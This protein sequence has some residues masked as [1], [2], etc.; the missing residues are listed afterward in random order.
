[1][2]E[3]CTRPSWCT[4][5]STKAPNAATFV[6]TPSSIMPGRQVGDLLDALL[7][8]RRLE[9]GPR[10]AA[11]LLQLLRMSVTVGRPKR[12][13]HEVGRAAAAQQRRVL[14]I[15]DAHVLPAVCAAMRRT[16]G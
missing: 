8:G 10:V 12:L 7:E 13:V 6:T 4:P 3:T 11:R 14:P 9:R 1:M 15:S 5:T 16:T 2:A